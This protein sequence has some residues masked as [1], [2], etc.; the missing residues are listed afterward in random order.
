M[1]SAT[2]SPPSCENIE[3]SEP[4]P[5]RSGG[6]HFLFGLVCR[7]EIHAAPHPLAEPVLQT[8]NEHFAEARRSF[9]ADE[10]LSE[11]VGSVDLLLQINPN[12]KY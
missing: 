8:R 7:Q 5:E 2:G 3:H 11:D 4:K 6:E 9:L 10:A 1:P 12:R